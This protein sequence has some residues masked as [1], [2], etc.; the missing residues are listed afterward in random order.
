MCVPNFPASQ[1]PPPSIPH[2]SRKTHSPPSYSPNTRSP[3]SYHPRCPRFHPPLDPSCSPCWHSPP[4]H[5]HPNPHLTS[6]RAT[7][8]PESATLATAPPQPLAHPTPA[9]PALRAA[10]NCTPPYP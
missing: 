8:T 7:I 6:P 5:P 2:H 10:T 4:F 9:T 1:S 3:Y